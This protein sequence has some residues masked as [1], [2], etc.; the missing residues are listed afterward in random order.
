MVA[1]VLASSMAFIDATALNVVLPSLQRSLQGDG[2]EL[3][4]IL[5]AYLLMLASLI[6]IGGVLGDKLGRKRVY[7]IG[8][9]IFL[10]GSVACGCSVSTVMLIS[11]RVI[12]GAGGALMIPGSLSLLSALIA[13]EERGRA[14]GT[15]SALTTIVTV[16]GPILGGALAD[17]G[18]WRDIFFVNV[19]LGLA[20]LLILWRKVPESRA[21]AGRRSLDIEG[22]V[23]VAAGLALETWGCLRIPAVGLGNWSVMAA[24][25]GGVIFLLAFVRIEKRSKDPMIP[26]SLFRNP[27]FSGV[28]A[29]TFFL[30][31]GLGAVFL[32]LSLNM[33]QIQG[34]SQ[35]Q[36]GLSYLP[37]TM[38]LIFLSRYVGGWA[39]RHGPRGL[40]IAGP[41]IAGVGDDPIVDV[42]AGASAFG[43]LV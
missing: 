32:F 24:L 39:D 11:F 27:V 28:N 25:V 9:V 17:A 22:A 34:Y 30:Y 23:A 35:L 1:A 7:M 31:A 10:I 36:A 4:W 43:L 2:T 13:D 40:L 26:L 19:P 3:F 42:R 33:V 5:N 6:L 14:I 29:L 38:L 41:L 18:L 16:G 20:S 12:Q 15:W 37:F 8:I 21:G